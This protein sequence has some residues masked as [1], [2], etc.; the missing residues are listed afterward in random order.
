MMT[1]RDQTKS[2]KRI[3]SGT[4]RVRLACAAGVLGALLLASRGASA[5]PCSN[6]PT[7]VYVSGSAVVRSVIA[8]LATA[9]AVAGGG[10]PTIVFAAT[11]SCT[12]VSNFVGA[13]PITGT[14]TFW[15]AT[16]TALSCDLD[17]SGTPIDIAVS[18]LFAASCGLAPLP[19]TVTD[20][21]AGVDPL[22]FFVPVASSRQVISANAAYFVFGFG[23]TGGV[24][25]W[26]DE[27]QMFVRTATATSQILLAAAIGVPANR[28][29]G[30]AEPSS[31]AVLSA[32]AA[33]VSPES[34]IG[35]LS[36]DFADANRNVTRALAYQTSSTSCGQLPDSSS[37]S[38]DKANV[39]SGTYPLWGRTHYVASSTGNPNAAAVVSVLTGAASGPPGFSALDSEI[40]AHLVP[41][42]AMTVTRSADMGPLSAFSAADPCTCYFAMKTTGATSC[43]VCTTNAQC[44]AGKS[45]HHGFCE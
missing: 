31:A 26:T 39:R 37:T 1:M 23:A 24:T 33:A 5:A 9:N 2:Q 14:A 30:V 43:Q 36:S 10:A 42:C 34:A 16:G 22:G 3:F 6:L 7:P 20:S 4:R 45:C 13:I 28:W 44:G 29:K 25:P 17:P 12:A 40:N 32:L 27:S 11:A 21:A 18:D 41:Q 15:D 8:A 19:A 35:I 38:F